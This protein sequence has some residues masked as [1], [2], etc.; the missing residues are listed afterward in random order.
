MIYLVGFRATGKSTIGRLAAPEL[1]MDFI[2]LDTLLCEEAGMSVDE[3]V[4]EEGWPGFRA[5][6]KNILLRTAYMSN[7][8]VATGG[9]AVMHQDVWPILKKG[10][11]V[12]WIDATEDE[13]FRRLSKKKND[14]GRPALTDQSLREE[15]ASVLG[16]RL[17]LYAKIADVTLTTDSG[18]VARVVSELISSISFSD[19]NM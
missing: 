13:V 4:A 6:E 18:S 10:G 16:E 11:V 19:E 2:D 9:G 3:I 5:R 17:P 8:I 15:I 1:G 12:V 14:S 7:T